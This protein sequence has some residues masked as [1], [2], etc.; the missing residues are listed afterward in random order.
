[1]FANIISI[2]IIIVDKNESLEYYERI[3]KFKSLNIT[4]VISKDIRRGRKPV[5]DIHFCN[6][7]SKEY[8]ELLADWI[9]KKVITVIFEKNIVQNDK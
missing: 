6:G 2:L 1:M 8:D 9:T 4:K 7:V 3:F 5:A